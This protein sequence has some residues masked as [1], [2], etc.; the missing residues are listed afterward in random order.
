MVSNDCDDLASDCTCID[1]SVSTDISPH[2]STF[3]EFPECT[4]LHYVDNIHCVG[5]PEDDVSSC[6]PYITD[7]CIFMCDDYLRFYK[8][9]LG[10][11]SSQM[12][13]KC[14]E[15]YLGYELNSDIKDYLSDGIANGFAIVDSDSEIDGYRCTN[16][17]SVLSADA[18]TYVN[19][20]IFNEIANGKYVRATTEPLCIHAL[21]AVPKHDGTFRP[22][23]DCKRPIGRSINNFM[24]STFH[25]FT[26]CTVDQVACSMQ[27]NCFM[28]TVDIASAYRSVPIRPDQWKFQA[29][30]WPIDGELCDLL[31][32]HLSFGLRCAPY[33]FTMIS[34]FVMS[35]MSRL[36]YQHVVNYIDD[37]LVFGNSFGECQQAQTVLIHLLGQLG[38]HVSW[39][40][41][42]SP[43]Q[44][45]RYLGINFDS[46]R[47]ELSLPDDKLSK[48]FHEMEFFKDRTRATRKQL[49]RLCGVLSHCSK[50]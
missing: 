17:K 49:Q 22:I 39:K 47:M 5:S 34:N 36:G 21:G 33:I 38:F 50:L 7:S 6:L 23:T 9:D 45:V 24:E 37:F 31:D 43:T 40:K 14:W 44:K 3:V 26:Y 18:F 30:S 46:V 13:S 11:Y 12:N 2:S 15:Y 27:E 28:A 25:Q 35:T 1:S 20:L 10:G 19:D 32:T 42:A 48:L 16:Y 8:H 29:V 41:C 4:Q